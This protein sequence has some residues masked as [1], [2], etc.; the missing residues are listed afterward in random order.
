MQSPLY[1]SQKNDIT[2]LTYSFFERAS[3][4]LSYDQIVQF[5]AVPLN[6]Q[7]PGGLGGDP[8][9]QIP[10]AY[11]EAGNS[12]KIIIRHRSGAYFFNGSYPAIVHTYCGLLGQI[13]SAG[14]KIDGSLSQFGFQGTKGVL[15]LSYVP[16]SLDFSNLAINTYMDAGFSSTTYPVAPGVVHRLISM[17]IVSIE[18]HGTN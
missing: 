16:E 12:C 10:N 15:D 8:V 4:L 7:L 1:I 9:L 17:L 5:G 11:R 3:S 13:G 2:T 14:L 18:I 6:T